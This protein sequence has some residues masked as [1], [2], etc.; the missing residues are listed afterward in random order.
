MILN[1]SFKAIY[2]QKIVNTFVKANCVQKVRSVF[3]MILFAPEI[4][5][6]IGDARPVIVSFARRKYAVCL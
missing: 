4:A 6:H 5:R 2:A 3:V 1:T